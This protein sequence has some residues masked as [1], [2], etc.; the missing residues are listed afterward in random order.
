MLVNE[1]KVPNLE[2]APFQVFYL[3]LILT[4]IGIEFL[5]RKGK[6]G[7]LFKIFPP[8]AQSW[9]LK[10]ISV[11]LCIA[12]SMDRCSSMNCLSVCNKRST[13]MESI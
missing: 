1:W 10:I 11:V 12:W 4:C 8:E 9:G 5:Q 13:E 6:P 2:Q 3:G 7:Q